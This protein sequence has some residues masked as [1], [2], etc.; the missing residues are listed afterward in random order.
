MMSSAG[1]DRR[2]AVLAGLT[3]T[4]QTRACSARL[5]EDNVVLMTR[6]E[7]RRRDR[8]DSLVRFGRCGEVLLSRLPNRPTASV[9]MALR[10]D[11][12]ARQNRL[13]PPDR[14]APT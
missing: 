3:R 1:P 8:G 2:T 12:R 14:G 4:L 5:T 10:P 7:A 6:C 9:T 11:A 13:F